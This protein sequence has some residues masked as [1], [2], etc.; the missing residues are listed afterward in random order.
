MASEKKS[1]VKPLNKGGKSNESILAN[2]QALRVDQRMMASKLSELE[3]EV[4][5]HKY[6]EFGVEKKKT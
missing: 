2:F 3:L 5:E 6:V 4:N 1:G